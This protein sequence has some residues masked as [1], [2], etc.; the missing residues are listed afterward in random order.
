MDSAAETTIS[1]RNDAL[2]PNQVCET[3]NPIGNQFWVL[4]DIGRVADDA[5]Q[6]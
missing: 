3:H 5:G 6:D 1:R 2:A 4:D